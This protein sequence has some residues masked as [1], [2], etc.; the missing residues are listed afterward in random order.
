MLESEISG[1]INRV[2][3]SIS[4]DTVNN[5]Y[6]VGLRVYYGAKYPFVETIYIDFKTISTVLK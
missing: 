2:F 3:I 1:K 5:Q 6:V 4:W